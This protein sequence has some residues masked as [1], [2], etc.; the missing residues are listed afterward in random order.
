M[1]NPL[2]PKTLQQA[3]VFF[4][5]LD[6]CVN[7]LVQRRWPEGVTCPICGSDNVVFQPKRR[8]FQCKECRPKGQFSVKVGTV[9]ED[10]AI[11]L[12]KWLCAMWMLANCKNGVSSWEIHRAIGV[13][14]KSAW[15]M[16]QR[17]RLALQDDNN[18]GKLSGHIEVDETFIG[19]K[20]RNMHK[21]ALARRVAQFATPRTGRNQTTGKVAVMG[22]LERHGEIRTMVV[23]GTKRRH[24]HA[25]VTKHV[26]EGSN[27]YTDALRSYSNL[28]EQYLHNVVN[29][30][31]KYVEGNV[32]TNGLENFWSC[33]KRTIGGTY[34]SVEPFHLF[35]YLDE[36]SFRF[37]NRKTTDANR[38]HLAVSQIVGK[39]LTYAEVTGKDKDARE[40]S[41]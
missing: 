5:N 41:H 9:M 27:V 15:F 6:N 14:Q 20:A 35:R 13:T 34:I 17:L 7:Y 3:V 23:E 40:I 21:S 36:Q 38:F 37:N 25:Q 16:L 10:S 8:L 2:E 39:R 30:A 32:H 28:G 4:S 24:L 1:T 29:H 22:L 31:E 11:G 33:L 18:G 12:D 26:E 19:G